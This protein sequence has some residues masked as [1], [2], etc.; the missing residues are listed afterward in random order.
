MA[1]L[2][3]LATGRTNRANG[4]VHARRT[5][6]SG[7]GPHPGSPRRAAAPPGGMHHD[8]GMRG[9]MSEEDMATLED[10]GGTEAG[11]LYLQQMTADHEG[12]IEMAR[13]EV[14]AGENPQALALAQQ[15]IEAQEAEI[16]EMQQL[17]QE[18]PAS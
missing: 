12:A 16:Q 2:R 14:G 13:D 3:R 17:L 1:S 8:S 18:L 5:Q 4:A 6:R 11:R 15:V 7:D 9:M 10:A